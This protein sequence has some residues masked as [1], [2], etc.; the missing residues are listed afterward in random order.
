MNVNLLLSMTKIK[1]NFFILA[2]VFGLQLNAPLADAGIMVGGFGG[3]R[4]AGG[5]TDLS[6]G[7]EFET[8]IIPMIGLAAF[9][10]Q[11]FATTATTALGAGIAVHPIPLFGLKILGQG[12]IEMTGSTNHFLLRTGVAYE[13]GL[14]PLFIGPVFNIDFISGSRAYVYGLSAGID[15]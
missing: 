5:S 2:L 9:A 7:L 11:T 3:F 13:F 8:S 6:L 12:G 4:S 14:G 1:S 15:L 10:E